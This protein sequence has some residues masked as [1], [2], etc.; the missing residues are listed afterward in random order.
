MT[1]TNLPSD[2]T[3]GILISWSFISNSKELSSLNV[4]NYRNIAQGHR[5]TTWKSLKKINALNR[6]EIRKNK[7]QSLTWT[8]K[9][10]QIKNHVII[11]CTVVA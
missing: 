3:I 11:K 6:K 2:F 4:F 10:Y 9:Q 8:W 5:N 7:V 1:I